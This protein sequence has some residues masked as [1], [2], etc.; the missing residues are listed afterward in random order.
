MKKF[1]IP[2]CVALC[3]FIHVSQTKAQTAQALIIQTNSKE[4]VD[5]IMESLK[6]ADP[7]TYRLTVNYGTA[8]L[9]AIG[10]A[11][12][13]AV[14]GA[15]GYAASDVIVIQKVITNGKDLQNAVI[16]RLNT[17]LSQQSFKSVKVSAVNRK[18]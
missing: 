8:P 18:F 5:K 10:K 3:M 15:G 14:G 4:E 12:G 16:S 13:A 9:S 2:A 17:K 7:S 6:N 11:G 1:L